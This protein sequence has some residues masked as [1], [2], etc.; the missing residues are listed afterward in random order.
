MEVS[1]QLHV[2]AASPMGQELPVSTGYEVD[3]PQGQSRRGCKEKSSL[4]LPG[5]E[6]RSSTRSLIT[7][8][9]K[10]PHNENYDNGIIHLAF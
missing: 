6:S 2:P 1:G 3:V 8:L 7:M 10:L 9:T 4:L 5:S